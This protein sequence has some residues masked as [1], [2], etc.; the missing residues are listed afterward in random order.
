MKTLL[1]L[2]LLLALTPLAPLYA[3]SPSEKVVCSHPGERAKWLPETRIREI[4]GERDF[5]QVKLKISSGNCYEFYAIHQDGSIVEA[6]YHPISGQVMRYN[7]VAASP[8]AVT[9]QSTDR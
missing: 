5:T 9:Y 2:F 3:S 6:Y 7:R 1:G 8:G 4:F